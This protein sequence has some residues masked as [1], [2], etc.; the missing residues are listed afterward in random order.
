MPTALEQKRGVKGYRTIQL[1]GGKYLHIALTKKAGPEGG[2]TIAGP[3]RQRKELDWNTPRAEADQI[4]REK[5][6]K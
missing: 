3:V 5:G 2:H 4:L 6:Y 1:P